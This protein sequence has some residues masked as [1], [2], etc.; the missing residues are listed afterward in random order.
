MRRFLALLVPAALLLLYMPAAGA[1]VTLPPDVPPQE[2]KTPATAEAHVMRLSF[3]SSSDVARFNWSGAGAKTD[4]IVEDSAL[5]P[6]F[7]SIVHTGSR[8]IYR[9]SPLNQSPVIDHVVRHARVLTGGSPVAPAEVQ[10]V[11]VTR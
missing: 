7:V 1:V 5:T 10:A 2:T 4:L 6:T 11:V 3:A 8:M 9:A